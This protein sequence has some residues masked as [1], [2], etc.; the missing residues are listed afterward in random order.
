MSQSP[1]ARRRRWRRW[2]KVI[3]EECDACFDEIIVFKRSMHFANTNHSITATNIAY[4]N[5]IHWY[6]TTLAINLRRLLDN[7]DRTYSLFLLLYDIREHST[8]LSRRSFEMSYPKHRRGEGSPRFD[9]LVGRGAQSV[10][11]SVVQTD[12][13][14]IKDVVNRIMPVVNTQVAHHDRRSR[15]RLGVRIE[16]MHQAF[17]VIGDKIHKYYDILLQS[18]S[19]SFAP[20]NIEEYDED[21]KAIWGRRGKPRP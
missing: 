1:S 8:L 21:I 15:S 2:I 16:A 17:E 13:D 6:G 3:W 11:R 10:P 20:N 4:R 18:P 5:T 9:E 12:F 14:T 7:D 19:P